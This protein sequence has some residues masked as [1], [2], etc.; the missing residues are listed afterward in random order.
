MTKT[1]MAVRGQVGNSLNS[2]EFKKYSKKA[3]SLAEALVALLIGSLILGMSAP[4]IT[5][6]LK[7][8]TF[9]DVQAQLL[10]RKV[11][12]AKDEI[13]TNANNIASI[14]NGRDVATYVQYIQTLENKIYALERTVSNENIQNIIN[15]KSEQK[16]YDSDITNLQNQINSKAS[17]SS[18]NSL[19]NN[20]ST[21][22]TDLTTVK[23]NVA[24]LDE[25]IKNL[26][27][28]GTVAFFNLSSCPAGWSAISSSWRGRFPRF[29]GSYTVLAY[30]ATNRVYKTTGTA[31][32]L[33][34]GAT[35]EDA[36]R[37]MTGRILNTH[38]HGGTGVLNGGVDAYNGG[39]GYVR[40]KQMWGYTVFDTARSVPVAI[41]NRPRSVALLGCVKN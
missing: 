7:H 40:G 23:T 3:F 22:S 18:V 38:P 36:I 26:V 13:T 28:A 27:P 11:E 31:Q 8:N 19:K 6:Q 5:K 21:F 1:Q 16:E 17:A 15:G 34:V 14:L 12:D 39:Y 41:E 2:P 37:P 9:T 25:K 30:D 33:N 32:A 35:Q 29:A 24:K 4:L 10:N 20:V